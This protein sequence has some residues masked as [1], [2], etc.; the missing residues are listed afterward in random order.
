MMMIVNQEKKCNQKAT[1]NRIY[2]TDYLNNKEDQSKE[3]LA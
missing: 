3:P 1:R 2:S